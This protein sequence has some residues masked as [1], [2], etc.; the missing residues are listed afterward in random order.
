LVTSGCGEQGDTGVG[1]GDSAAPA[2]VTDLAVSSTSDSSVVLTWTAPGD[3]GADGTASEYDLRHSSS[4]IT[5]A[6]WESATRVPDLPS[7]GPAG[8]GELFKV[9]ELLDGT[10]Y[11]FCLR[12]SDEVPN[13]SALSN[14]VDATTTSHC[15]SRSDG[16]YRGRP[17]D[18]GGT[19]YLIRAEI[20]DGVI[21]VARFWAECS[22]HYPDGSGCGRVVSG[23]APPARAVLDG[24]CEFLFEVSDRDIRI[25]IEG[26]VD[27]EVGQIDGAYRLYLQS[28]CS[29][30][31]QWWAIK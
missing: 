9:P 14:D 27:P 26:T 31:G 10:K 16:H 18:W 29:S 21:Y 15:D 8:A 7:P 17:S 4:T 13:W 23:F 30:R 11:H 22:G 1:A 28:C 5:G 6:S 3:D 20:R 2:A 24:N 12:T 25:E 19:A